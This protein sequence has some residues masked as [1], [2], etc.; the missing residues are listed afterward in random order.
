M[1]ELILTKESSNEEIKTYFEK[2]LDLSRSTENEFPV[3]LDEV[4]M[5]A[6]NRKDYATD[7]LVRDFIDGVDYQRTSARTEVGSIKYEYKISVPCLE[8]FIAR[9]IRPVFEVYRKVFHG[10]ANMNF[11]KKVPT[12][13][14]EA[15]R[16]AAEQQ[17]QIEAQQKLIEVQAPKAEFY[18]DVVESKDSMPMDK[19][20]KTLN[21]GIGINKLFALLR[22]EKILMRNNTPYQQYVD[23]GWFRCVESKFSKPNGDICINV[24]TVVLQKGL[25]GIRKLLRK[26]GYKSHVD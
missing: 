25:D 24:K 21:M 10:V 23:A 1:T 2:I 19:V 14:A 7:A 18:D 26:K 22:D 3:N 16:L 5:L 11:T 4:W 12:T 8:F 13:F 17:E 15:L 20:V 9:K 6:Y